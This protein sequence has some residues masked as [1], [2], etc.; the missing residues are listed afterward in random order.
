MGGLIG[1]ILGFM[2]FMK[3]FSLMSFELDIAEK[4]FKYEDGEDINFKCFN[5][6]TYFL[7]LIYKVGSYV[8]LCKSWREMKRRVDCKEEM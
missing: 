7:Y 8:G 6:F 3:H 5:I 4:F 1:T 2:L